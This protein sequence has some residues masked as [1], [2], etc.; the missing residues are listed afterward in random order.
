MLPPGA[1]VQSSDMTEPLNEHDS[2]PEADEQ[3]PEG[4]RPNPMYRVGLALLA[5]AAIHW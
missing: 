5:I 4:Q 2:E 1:F 3:A